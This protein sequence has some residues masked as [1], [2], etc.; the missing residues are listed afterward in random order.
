MHLLLGSA[1][2]VQLETE[3]KK[4]IDKITEKNEQVRI[5]L[6][7]IGDRDDDVQYEKSILRACAKNGI[8]VESNVYG[9]EIAEDELYKA[10]LSAATRKEIDGILIFRPLPKALR[11]EKILFAVPP[12]KDID[13]MLLEKSAFLPCTPEGCMHLLNAYGIHPKGKKCVVVGRSPVVGKPLAELLIKA[14]A[15]VTVCHTQTENVPAETRKAEILFA[16]CGK[17]EMI[18][19]NYLSTGQIVV[20]VGFHEKEGRFC[21]D[22]VKEDAMELAEAYTPVPG[23]VGAVT[24]SVLMLHSVQA[25]ERNYSL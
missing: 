2:K 8:T 4:H 7:R 24:L 23:G 9:T 5:S 25:H 11:T 12:E 10:I 6:F 21:G 16:A 19:R 13:G 22:V 1:A 17:P 15:D 18:D 14:G 20:D 3:V